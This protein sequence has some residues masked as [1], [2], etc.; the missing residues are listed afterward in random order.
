[1]SGV[2]DDW[3][4]EMKGIFDGVTLKDVKAIGKVVEL[5]EDFEKGVDDGWKTVIGLNYQN[6][7]NLFLARSI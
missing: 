2:P 7:W 6:T 5:G 4:N 3:I 1:M